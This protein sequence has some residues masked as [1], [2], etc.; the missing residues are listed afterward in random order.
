VS[1]SHYTIENAAG[2]R[3]PFGR[4]LREAVLRILQNSL[5][6]SAA[7]E[8]ADVDNG[9]REI[10]CTINKSTYNKSNKSEIDRKLVNYI[11]I[12]Y[13]DRP[14]GL[15]MYRRNIHGE[16]THRVSCP[17]AFGK[18]SIHLVAN[19]VG[20][21]EEVFLEGDSPISVE[22]SSNKNKQA[23]L[24]DS[25]VIKKQRSGTTKTAFSEV[26]N[27]SLNVVDSKRT[28]SKKQVVTPSPKTL[29][30][31][32]SNLEKDQR[33]TIHH[34]SQPVDVS[35][36][37]S[38]S[39]YNP[40]T[41]NS[42]LSNCKIGVTRTSS[43]E[44]SVDIK[45]R[46]F[47]IQCTPRKDTATV[48]LVTSLQNKPKDKNFSNSFKCSNS[49]NQKRDQY[50]N[51]QKKASGNS[52][53]ASNPFSSFKFDPNKAEAQL[54]RLSR[55]CTERGGIESV[56]PAN[57]NMSSYSSRVRSSEYRSGLKG[58][59]FLR[60]PS[61][62]GMA[63]SLIR[64]RRG[65][66]D[67]PRSTDI[68]HVKAN[69]QNMYQYER[70]KVRPAMCNYA[71]TSVDGKFRY[72]LP[73]T[74]P[75]GFSSHD[76]SSSHEKL[77]RYP[78]HQE[79]YIHEVEN[80]SH[81]SYP[82]NFSGKVPNPLLY[83]DGPPPNMLNGWCGTEHNPNVVGAYEDFQQKY[84]V[85]TSLNSHYF[86][87]EYDAFSQTFPTKYPTNN[88]HNINGQEVQCQ[89]LLNDIHPSYQSKPPLN[90]RRDSSSHMD[91]LQ[92]MINALNPSDQYQPPR[93][94]DHKVYGVEKEYLKAVEY[95]QDNES[96]IS[97]SENLIDNAFF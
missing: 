25:K 30:V 5:S 12:V 70:E 28:L 96:T 58:T 85:K 59:P 76:L 61:R 63:N 39:T 29:S 42:Y 60:T 84:D 56:I 45:A 19:L 32:I 77:E 17:K 6:V 8:G 91:K 38:P 62:P 57:I 95:S 15:L 66:P 94:Y 51:L 1:K 36:K 47:P 50:K 89:P 21:D 90:N 7:I 65:R 93:N 81:A 83:M 33:G 34:G 74:V 64:R 92:P 40:P 41:K 49:W 97:Q 27:A 86:Q 72:A 11:L 14:G 13:F 73:G 43:I 46:N 68:L 53:K 16:G 26:A 54:E 31:D 82:S 48:K 69:E 35:G 24:L 67:H 4:E 22:S 3:P 71:T 55:N 78:Q 37:L 9:K 88:C 52:P 75:Q 10:V 20:L 44:K 87:A 2:R 23:S 79:P 18:I 80:F